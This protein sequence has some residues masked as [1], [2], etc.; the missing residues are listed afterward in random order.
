MV[1]IPSMNFTDRV[2]ADC[3]ADSI[4]KTQNELANST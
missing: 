3:I 4:A 1:D 2:L